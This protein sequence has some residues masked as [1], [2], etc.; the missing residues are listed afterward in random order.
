MA[1]GS[2]PLARGLRHRHAHRR[3]PAGII[4][5][6]AGFTAE[7]LHLLLSEEDHPR[8]RGVYTQRPLRLHADLGSSP[9][10]RGL[11]SDS[12]ACGRSLGIIPAR[13]G[14]TAYPGIGVTSGRDHPRSRGVYASWKIPDGTSGG[15]SPLARGLHTPATQRGGS[16]RIIPARAGFTP[17]QR[18][19]HDLVRDHPR[20]RGVYSIWG[21]ACTM[22][23]G[24]SPLA[25]GLRH[26]H[27]HRRWPAG[28]IPAR[29]GFTAER[30]HLLL[31]EE[32]H[33]RSRGVYT[34]RPLRL[35]ADL[36]SS[37]LARGLHSDSGACGRSLG[38]IPARAGFTAYPGIGV[39]SGR[40]HPRSRGVYASWKIPDGTSGGSS[41]LARGLHTPATQRGGSR[42]IIP[43]RAGFT[44][45]Q[46]PGHDL[47]RDHPR[48]RGVYSARS[49]A[50][51]AAEGSSPL[52]RGL[53]AHRDA[54]VVRG[55]II[56]ARAGF[57][58][59]THKETNYAWDHP[60]SRGVYTNSQ[61][62]CGLPSGSS[63]LARG[64]RAQDAGAV[65][66]HRII[67]AR[68]GFTR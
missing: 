3:W 60:R 63:P 47:V 1:P 28:I 12:G 68:A 34:Q 65:L 55:G 53:P 51:R 38:I 40:D 56:P 19:G 5:A 25:R 32:D 23:P 27:A 13:A 21:S 44:P 59:G 41:P 10:A 11:H 2:S 48:S 26:R 16:R 39:T 54:R 50:D 43:A 36:G 66:V 46:R 57:T 18:P 62:S 67:P 20:S 49:G 15:S 30:L 24:S 31:S 42:R 52:A 6:R 9:L 29:A 35:H 58:H 61:S 4:P 14:F 7:R 8:S 45:A 33:P 37:P 64:L 17:A 22:A